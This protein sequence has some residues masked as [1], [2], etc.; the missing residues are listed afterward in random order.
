MHLSVIIPVFNERATILDVMER[1]RSAPL[2]EGVT[3]ELVVVDDASTD[4][5]REL[6]Q[7]QPTGSFHLVLHPENKGKSRAV[8]TGIAQAKGDFLI[9]QDADLE[10]DP[11]EYVLLL[12]PLLAGRADVVYGSRFHPAGGYAN[13]A[14]RLHI[15]GNRLL[16]GLSNLFSGLHLTDMETCYKLFRI[17]AI[18]GIPL[19]AERFGFEPEVT[20]KLARQ[21]RWRI[22]EVPITYQPRSYAQG[23]K[24][25]L[26]D[27]FH[28]LAVMLQARFFQPAEWKR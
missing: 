23:K 1:V 17:E 21:G 11:G 6:L 25:R 28:A 4:G 27:A 5:T 12:E 8:R 13:R 7:E 18:R 22:V 9:I 2:P 26:K 10:Y 14:G 3:R 20:I 16:T 15:F 19:L 24:I